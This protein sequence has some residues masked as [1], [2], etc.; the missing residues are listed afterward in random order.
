MPA[1]PA[2]LRASIGSGDGEALLALCTPLL[3]HISPALIL[4]LWVVSLSSPVAPCGPR[5]ATESGLDEEGAERWGG[6][7]LLSSLLA[8]KGVGGGGLSTPPAPSPPADQGHGSGVLHREGSPAD[9]A[10]RSLKFHE[11]G[12]RIAGA[13]D[14]K[15]GI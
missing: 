10:N 12:E 14:S 3:R 15:S 4:R 7:R 8:P 6:G 2:S 9:C 11:D 1:C 5:S 13:L